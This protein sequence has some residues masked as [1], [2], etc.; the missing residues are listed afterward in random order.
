M[1][2]K[3]DFSLEKAEDLCRKKRPHEALPYLRKALDLDPEN[4]D[5]M[6]QLAFLAPNLAS[7]VKTLE[8]AERTGEKV[9]A[10]R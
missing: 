5:A 6:I 2:L 8:N 9:P 10:D 3:S 4:L 7:S 1:V